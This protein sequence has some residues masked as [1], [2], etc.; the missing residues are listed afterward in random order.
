MTR[1]HG[2]VGFA[3][4]VE[5]RP[6][7]HKEVIQEFSYF[8]DL[9]R[10]TRRFERP[11]KVNADISIENVVKIVA[12]DTLLRN[13]STIRYVKWAGVAW[14][15]TSVEV[16]HPRLVL[17]MGGVYNGETPPVAPDP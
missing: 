2:E 13:F 8:G 3:T 17:R 5:E 12:D 14:V 15:V 9:V 6:G 10:D 1:F 4:S 11:D 16:S 7:Y